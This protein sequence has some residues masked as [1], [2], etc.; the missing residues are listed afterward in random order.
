M[1]QLQ[2]AVWTKIALND[3]NPEEKEIKVWME[4]TKHRDVV[5]ESAMIAMSKYFFAKNKKRKGRHLLRE[6]LSTKTGWRCVYFILKRI[7]ILTMVNNDDNI[8]W[9]TI[10]FEKKFSQ[11][12]DKQ[13][14]ENSHVIQ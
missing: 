2:R 14:D 8:R 1:N 3:L 6:V 5:G 4:M 12:E 7:E 10:L 11:L 13:T 9:V